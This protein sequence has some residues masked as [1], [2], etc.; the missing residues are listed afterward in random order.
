MT[1][2]KEKTRRS[3]PSAHPRAGNW[4]RNGIAGNGIGNELETSGNETGNMETHWKQDR[5]GLETEASVFGRF[6][7]FSFPTGKESP[8]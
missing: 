1:H 3:F 2:G 6:S 8:P 4:K 7:P 5:K